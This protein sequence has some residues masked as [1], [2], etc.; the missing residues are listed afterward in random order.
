[1]G[2]IEYV[3]KVEG[4]ELDGRVVRLVAGLWR[5][6]ER[7]DDFRLD[8]GGPVRADGGAV[9]AGVAGGGGG[10]MVP[11]ASPAEFGAEVAAVAA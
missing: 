5:L 7:M 3:V 2:A 10:A 6:Y 8:D 4:A 1:M 11:A 9:R